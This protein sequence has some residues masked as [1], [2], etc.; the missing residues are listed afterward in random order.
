MKNS[1][2]K[3]Q[4]TGQNTGKAWLH[5]A[6]PLPR[7]NGWAAAPRPALWLTPVSSSLRTWPPHPRAGLV[8]P[9]TVP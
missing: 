6:D 1:R 4:K 2:R 5:L 3:I 9:E 7:R 8:S